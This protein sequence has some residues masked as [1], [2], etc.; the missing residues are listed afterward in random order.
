[1][2]MTEKPVFYSATPSRWKR[3]MWVVKI[4]LV[5]FLIA[6]TSLVASLLHR[7]VLKL[8]SLKD[9]PEANADYYNPVL[10]QKRD[11]KEYKYLEKIIAEARKTKHHDFYENKVTLPQGVRQYIPVH[12]G[13]YVNWDV[14]A[15]YS[16]RRNISHMN[17]VLPE[18]F[19]IQDSSDRIMLDVDSAAL[20]IMRLGRIAIVP[21]VSNYFNNKWNG[22]NVHRIIQSPIRRK[23]LITSIIDALEKYHFN[24]I[25][26]DFEDLKETTDEYM[27]S[28]QQELSQEL[29]K[30][31]LIV[32]QDIAP[33][34][35]DYNIKELSKVNDLLFLMAYDEHNSES[36]PGPVASQNWVE[37]S[38]DDILKKTDPDKVVLCIAAYGYDWQRGEQGTDVTYQEAISTALESEGKVKFDNKSF[39]LD[40]SYY[41]DDD[42]YHEVYF[43]D[44][45]T[46]YNAIRAAVDNEIAGYSLWR[47]GSEDIRV[48]KFFDNDVSKLKLKDSPFNY[49]ELENIASSYN[50]DYVGAGEI[51][52]VISTPQE[53]KTQLEYNV[54]EQSITEEQY[55][56]LPSSF[57]INKTGE[58]DHQISLTF[59]DGPD[60]RYTPKILDILKEYKVPAVFFVTGIN[61][62]Q[63]LELV[64]RI[65][66]EGH[67]LG[68][69]TFIHPN[70][71]NISDQRLELELRSTGYIIEG[72]TGHATMFFRPPYNTDAEPVNP[73]QIEPLATAKSEGYL[74]IGSS[75]DPLDWQKG[76]A[77]DT[78][79]ARAIRQHNL[80]NIILMH[81]AGGTRDETVK[82]LPRIIEYYQTHGYKFV[83][84]A[85]LMGKKRDEVMPVEQGSLNH[86][87]ESTDSKVFVAGY[88]INRILSALFF[89]ALLLSIIKISS[90]AILAIIQRRTERKKLIM[91]FNSF[92]K[93]S[94][95]VPAYNEELNAV[96]TV[97]NLLKTDYPEF[98]IIFVDDGSKDSTY[99][100]VKDEYSNHP[101]VKVLSKVNG[102]KASALNFG[103][104]SA[105]GEI[106]VCIDAD[107]LLHTDAIRKLIPYFEDERVGAVAGNVKVGN[108]INL[109]TLWQHLEYTTSQNF[110]RRAFDTLN[111]IMVVPG[112]IGAFRK[113]AVL[114]SGAFSTDTLAEDCDLT[115][116]LLRKNFIV[117][118]CNEALAYTEVPEKMNMLVKQRLRWSFGIM[119]SFWKHRDLMFT[120]KKL[121][122]SWVLLPHLLIFQLILPLISPLVDITFLISLF[123]PQ[124]WLIV[125]FY[126]AYFALDLC[127]SLL[128]FKIENEEFK[129]VFIPV[130]F[131]QRIIY[132]QVLWYVLLKSYLRAIKGELATWGFLN[133][134]GNVKQ[135]P[136]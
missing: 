41:D 26:I 14:Q 92:P 108:R 71:E 83:S 103:I 1:M 17:M 35:E 122:M 75:I 116:R 104:G 99:K 7:Q 127:I 24:G 91:P 13:F 21:M 114:Q 128:S 129:A 34:N 107:T 126:F 4:F 47:L 94:I 120:R 2:E 134:T 42:K 54:N 112:A 69:H 49:H 106:L 32:T 77:A 80:G 59:D 88:Y 85:T 135:V 58:K 15:K 10:N 16:L 86:L 74:T 72:I 56:K 30:R 43:T 29:H 53:G 133:R 64:R 110:E 31:G 40:F 12:A 25:N 8:P 5:V 28:F 113:D 11:D 60:E 48:W 55:L 95:I 125:V 89:A 118:C 51:L 67:E 66:N 36:N 98:E 84:L 123:M 3:F 37:A 39:N 65:Y 81:D 105:D 130:L 132:R 33:F 119:Q 6:T 97:R 19:F 76:V 101:N 79:V 115:L 78:I 131:L 62:E 136:V 117:K 87:L 100:V 57:V 90:V 18:W 46:N 52:N 68:N 38:M 82:A 124:S 102:G 50:V 9:K 73:I 27:I 20:E 93:V 111:A 109:L 96:K 44:A 61:A 23:V 45:A 63:N 121:N 70:L 22:N